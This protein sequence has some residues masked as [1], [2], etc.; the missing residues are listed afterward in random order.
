[1]VLTHAHIDH[2]G[3]TPLLLKQGFRGPV[4]CTRT[5]AEL[6]GVMLLDSAKIAAEDARG[7][8]PPAAFDDRDVEDTVRRMRPLAYGRTLAA[9]EGA[10]VT[11]SDAGHI[12]GSAHVLLSLKE[13]GRTLDVG[14]SGDVG[15]PGRPVV[16]DPQPFRGCDVLQ[17]ESTYGE[18]DHRPLKESVDALAEV[19]ARTT[20]GEGVVLVPAFSL[21]R[22]QDVLYL[23]NKWKEAGKLRDLPVYVDSPLASRV[24]GV[25][26]HNKQDYDEDV[27]RL[28]SKGDDP[29]SF[30]DLHFVGSHMESE[31]LKR[32]V[33]RGLVIASSGMCQSGRIR[34]W[35][36]AC[37]PR[38]STHV[39]IVG[40]QAEGTLGRRLVEGAKWVGLGGR[41]VPVNASVH[42]L[43]GFSAHAGR[44]ELLAWI[45]AIERRP[46]RIY[47]HHGEPRSLDA[48]AQAI[49]SDLGIETVIPSY[50]DSFPL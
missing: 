42:T 35:L 50:G 28:L 18:R 11:L 30:D 23:L 1:V 14:I 36:E 46:K 20:E 26:D 24:T 6:A 9:G 22:T 27:K 17:I 16:A 37:L 7:G 8:G 32:E 45:R 40:Y 10:S 48:F 13:E 15:C 49:R 19:L 44:K 39:V 3:R 33:R 43:G 41:Q 31:R 25:F 47:L 12:L 21:G 29:F 38:P 2:I 4:L 34:G 5:T